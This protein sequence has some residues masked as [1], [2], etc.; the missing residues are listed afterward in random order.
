[1]TANESDLILLG[2][3]RH[4]QGS[5]TDYFIN[6]AQKHGVSEKT[7]LFELIYSFNR[8]YKIV[9]TA[10]Y[11]EW[12]VNE[13]G[14]REPS[15]YCFH[16]YEHISIEGTLDK[17]NIFELLDILK[18]FAKAFKLVMPE[19]PQAKPGKPY[20]EKWFSLLHLILCKLNKPVPIF[21]EGMMKEPVNYAKQKYFSANNDERTGQGFYRELKKI[22]INNMREYV[23]NL[24]PL[25]RK[26]W[27]MIITEISENDADV[28]EWLT[29]APK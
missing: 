13:D 22:D 9:N 20:P 25:D 16:L 24:K 27:K 6:E 15:Y 19:T 21:G 28:S 26:N 12:G 11:D 29:T 1:M 5:R 2:A 10:K 17:D 3:L 7:L 14:N 8:F 4:T 18:D 23:R